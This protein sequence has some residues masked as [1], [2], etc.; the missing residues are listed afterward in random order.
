MCRFVHIAALAGVVLLVPLGA[1]RPSLG[2][3][4]EPDTSA[5]MAGITVDGVVVLRD[6]G[7]LA[8]RISRRADR[9]V[10]TLAHGEISLPASQVELVADSPRD[11]YEQQRRLVS[12]PTVETHLRLAEWCLR[13]NLGPQAARELVD[14]R[15]LDPRHPKLA[16]LERRLAVL[17]AA[18]P[19]GEA[20][21]AET[22]PPDTSPRDELDRLAKLAGSLPDG[23]LE[24]FTRKVQPVLVNSCTTSGCHQPESKQS[25]QLNRAMLHGLSNRRS[26]LRNLEATLELV[27]RSAPQESALLTVPHRAHGGMDRP[28]FGPRQ[29]QLYEHL[30]QWVAA[31]TESTT[32]DEPALAGGQP[33]RGSVYD[34]ASGKLQ[35]PI[36][37]V[38]Y[39]SGPE[40]GETRRQGD[41]ETGRQGAA[42]ATASRPVSPYLG[43]SPTSVLVPWQPKDP[44]DPEIFN[45]QR[46]SGGGNATAGNA[47]SA[48]TR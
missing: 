44:F 1:S 39:E 24:E 36:R 32:V 41:K 20:A 18:H 4:A 23:T 10:V 8:G 40:D 13:N 33:T 34:R 29:D 38:T 6:G 7:V 48:T 21:A 28:V 27:D 31:V 3:A 26:T 47:T 16:L 15:G 30:A 12:H 42:E 5:E 14:A 37:R 19:G 46:K 22:A 11:A 45:R 43:I 35:E 25:F 2:L 9:Y 17:G